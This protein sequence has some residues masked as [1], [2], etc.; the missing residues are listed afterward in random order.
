MKGATI[1]MVAVVACW[2][3]ARLTGGL[4]LTVLEV[5]FSKGGSAARYSMR[6]IVSSSF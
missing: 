2:G 1:E 6:D 4:Q 3:G 5:A